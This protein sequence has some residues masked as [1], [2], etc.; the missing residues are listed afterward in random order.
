MKE[1]YVEK[2]RTLPTSSE[3]YRVVPNCAE[4]SDL[5]Q[6]A[7]KCFKLFKTFKYCVDYSFVLGRML[8]ECQVLDINTQ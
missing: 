6:I 3:L 2:F 5:Y 8:H 4:N 7:K 1:S